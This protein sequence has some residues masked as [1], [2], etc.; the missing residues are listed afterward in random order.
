MGHCPHRHLHSQPNGNGLPQHEGGS[1]HSNTNGVE[2]GSGTRAQRARPACRPELGD[3]APPGRR[4]PFFWLGGCVCWKSTLQPCL[5]FQNARTQTL[6]E[7]WEVVTLQQ[8]AAARP[9]KQHTKLLNVSEKHCHRRQPLRNPRALWDATRLQTRGGVAFPDGAQEGHEGLGF[10]GTKHT[11]GKPG[12]S[13]GL[14]RVSEHPKAR[15]QGLQEGRAR[16]G[17]KPGQPGFRPHG[18]H[19]GPV[20]RQRK[21]LSL[22]QEGRG[23]R[24]QDRLKVQ[25]SQLGT[26]AA[27]PSAC[28]RQRGALRSPHSW[29]CSQLELLLKQMTLNETQ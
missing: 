28:P 14:G 21:T 1:F 24:A 15:A 22:E 12:S 5:A 3:A 6:T 27:K 11:L 13:G 18:G 25:R 23:P 20:H 2:L 19:Q 29:A 8:E 17:R 4:L 26:Q 9:R 16:W 10:Q 7:A